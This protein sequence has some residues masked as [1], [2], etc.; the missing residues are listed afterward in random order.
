VLGKNEESCG[1]VEENGII[2]FK[3]SHKKLQLSKGIYSINLVV[4]KSITKEPVYRIN[5]ILPFQ[6][7][8]NDETWEPFLLDSNFEKIK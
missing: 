3:V 1:I 6:I 7:L 8:H 2:R 5:N 4:R